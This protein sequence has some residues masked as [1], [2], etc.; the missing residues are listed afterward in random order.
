MT[1]A[2]RSTI[3]KAYR[4]LNTSLMQR[5]ILNGTGTTTNGA[6]DAVAVLAVG[7]RVNSGK[8]ED[9]SDK[10]PTKILRAEG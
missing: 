10:N 3:I 1:A 2:D 5:P 9:K 6:K 8:R 7:M 4:A